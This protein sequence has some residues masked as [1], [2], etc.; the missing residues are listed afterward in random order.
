MAGRITGPINNYRRMKE[1]KNRLILATP[2]VDLGYNFI[3]SFP[4]QRQEIDFLLC[5]VRNKSSFWQRLGR[6][7]RV[8]GRKETNIPSQAVMLMPNSICYLRT[9][10]FEGKSISRSKLNEL[11]D[12]GDKR[13]KSYALIREGLFTAT[14]QLNEIENILPEQQKKIVVSV[15][16]TLKECLDASGLTSDWNTFRK[17]H[18]LSKQFRD[19][20]KKYGTL[21]TYQINAWVKNRSRE[22]INDGIYKDPIEILLG[23]WAKNHFYEKGQLE[24][25]NQ[26]VAQAGIT[27]LLLA[28]FRKNPKLKKN[29][30]QYY[31]NQT[32]RLNYLFNFRGGAWEN[33]VWIYDPEQLFS[34]HDINRIDLSILLSKYCFYGPITH[35]DAEKNWKIRLPK[36]DMFFKITDFQQYPFPPV[37]EYHGVLPKR[38]QKTDYNDDKEFDLVPCFWQTIALHELNLN[39]KNAK[40]GYLPIPLGIKPKLT[41]LSELFFITPM[42]NRFILDYW[43]KEYEVRTG[44]LESETFAGATKR[45]GVVFGKD[46]ILISEEL[47]YRIQEKNANR[48]SDLYED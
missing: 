35:T 2:T 4:K 9:H 3:K 32:L 18:W 14:H 16:D 7:G 44:T 26:F 17:R 41:G 31:K 42:E 33:Q 8:L 24:N 39:F 43:L 38:P 47:Y 25:Y 5:S 36:S 22:N 11:I 29:V 30:I 28:L 40:L 37:F 21:T 12:L 20:G 27:P 48:A 1:S 15:F 23:S 45:H 46:A 10:Q 6:A 34:A 19:I 13:L